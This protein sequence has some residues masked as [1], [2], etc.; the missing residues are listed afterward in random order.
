MMSSI[1][2]SNLKFEFE[3]RLSAI[4]NGQ[5]KTKEKRKA[6]KE[7]DNAAQGADEE[8]DADIML[9]LGGG[10]FGRKKSTVKVTI[11]FEGT[12]PPEGL[13]RFNDSILKRVPS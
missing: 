4:G 8:S 13:V 6:L 5:S 3:A 7:G 1:R 9:D 11:E 10:F 2:I 12:D